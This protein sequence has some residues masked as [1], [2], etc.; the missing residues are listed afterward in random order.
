MPE[1]PLQIRLEVTDQRSDQYTLTFDSS[2]YPITLNLDNFTFSDW[3]RRLRPVLVGGND[4]AG[5]MC[6]LG[7]EGAGPR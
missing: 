5:G 2:Q 3:L 4:P 7:R 6:L 1:K